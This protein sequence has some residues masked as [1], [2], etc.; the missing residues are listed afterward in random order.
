MSEAA[1]PTRRLSLGRNFSWTLAGNLVFASCQWGIL[2]ILA[3]VG[4]PVAVGRFAL[5]SAVATPV[6]MLANLQL[7]VVQATDAASS[8]SFRDYLS[9]RSVTTSLAVGA[10]AV[11]AFAGYPPAQA[12]V[13][14]AFGLA[15]AVESFSDIHHGLFQKWERLDFVAQSIALRGA[16]GLALVAVVFVFTKSVLLAVGTMSVAALLVLAGLDV[17][18]AHRF[19]VRTGRPASGRRIL[20]LVLVSGPLGL[21][22]MLISLE[23]S[24]P[25][26]FVEG[27]LGEAPLGVFAALTYVT[28]AG[29]AVVGALSQAA[30]PR[31]ARF[32]AEGRRQAFAGLAAGL[33]VAALLLGA[34]GVAGAALFGRP[35]LAVIYTPEYGRHSALFVWIMAAGGVQYVASA[36]GAPVSAMR[37]F[38]VQLWIH[39]GSVALLLPL[40]WLLIRSNGLVGAVH[41]VLACTVLLV[42]CYAAVTVTGIVGASSAR[43]AVT[44]EGA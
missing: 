12:A 28:A 30:I 9:T 33:A 16:T 24:I 5:A 17:R 31:L 39:L 29:T 32:F 4:T 26:Y 2:V 7:R 43:A 40:A 19:A 23:S 8:F 34:A 1:T 14:L 25:R 41:A 21:T 44:G 18:R 11:I 6:V 38:R 37:R 42:A 3:K 15:R 36:L 22:M 10:I 20:D 13:I 27:R 35:L